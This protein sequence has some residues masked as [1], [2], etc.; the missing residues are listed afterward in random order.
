MTKIFSKPVRVND[1]IANTVNL[2][3]ENIGI[4]V[5]LLF[6]AWEN[7]AMLCNIEEDIFEITKAYDKTTQEKVYKILHRYFTSYVN[8]KTFI[9][10]CLN[11]TKNYSINTRN[12]I[13]ENYLNLEGNCYFQKAQ[14]LEWVRVNG[15]FI[16]Q[17][18]AGKIGGQSKPNQNLN[19]S[20]PPIP[21]I[22]PILNKTKYT[23][24]FEKVWK[25]LTVRPGS[26]SKAFTSFNKLSEEDKKKVVE[27]YNFLISTVNDPKFYPHVSSWLNGD[28][29]DEDIQLGEQQIRSLNDLGKDHKYNGFID[30]KHHFVYDMGFAKDLVCYDKKGKKI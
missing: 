12:Y 11:D 5:R 21:I 14:W 7:K 17:S 20:E 15:N 28:R 22:K 1:F 2:S 13:E 10:E 9:N 3:N 29:I 30:G 26:K 8:F 23:E 27:N 25:D 24:E 18:N 19:K 6:Y 16:S 4:Y